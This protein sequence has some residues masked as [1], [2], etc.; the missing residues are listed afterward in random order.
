MEIVQNGDPV[1]REVAQALSETDIGSPK[2]NKVLVKMRSA[3]DT[4]EDGVA[5]A[6]PQIGEALRIFIVHPRAWKDSVV[7]DGETLVYINPQIVRKSKEKQLMDEGCLSV[8]GFYGKTY[9]HARVSVEACDIFG[10]KFKRGASGLLA[11]IFQH[12]I[13]HLDGILFIDH[14]SDLKKAITDI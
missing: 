4:C 7:P 10:K 1:L 3:L 11:Q 14:A 13:D 9:R 2:I 12:E 8:R 5:L 6:A